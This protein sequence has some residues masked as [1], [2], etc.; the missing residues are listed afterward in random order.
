[1]TTETT[2][3]PYFYSPASGGFYLEGLHETIPEDAIA[4]SEA[5]WVALVAARASSALTRVPW[6]C[7]L[8]DRRCQVP[9]QVVL[10]HCQRDHHIMEKE[11]SHYVTGPITQR[12]P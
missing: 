11:W 7:K 12:S 8:P 3:P 10:R 4:I 6:P 1:M 9:S 5:E 2:P